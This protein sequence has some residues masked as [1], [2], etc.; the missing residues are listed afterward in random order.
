MNVKRGEEM[1]HV[2]KKLMSPM[3]MKQN[4]KTVEAA[5]GARTK[6]TFSQNMEDDDFEQIVCDDQMFPSVSKGKQSKDVKNAEEAIHAGKSSRAEV[7][8]ADR[9]INA[10][11]KS[12]VGARRDEDSG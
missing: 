3:K 8:E 1:N 10:V 4:N 7:R 9:K 12:A 11:G 6:S 5:R 2:G